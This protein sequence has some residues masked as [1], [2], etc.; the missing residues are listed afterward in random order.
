MESGI[1]EYG[2]V[3]YWQKVLRIEKLN[4][5]QGT[6]FEKTDDKVLAVWDNLYMKF[7]C[8]NKYTNRRVREFQNEI[9]I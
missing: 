8:P 5:L 3:V 4:I 2:F 9:E 6:T 7:L 1:I